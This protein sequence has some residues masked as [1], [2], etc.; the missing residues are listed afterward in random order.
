MGV[1]DLD[2][3][4]LTGRLTLSDQLIPRLLIFALQL[5][6]VTF[7]LV[8]ALSTPSPGYRV[9]WILLMSVVLVPG[10]YYSFTWVTI[11]LDPRSRTLTKERRPLFLRLSSTRVPFSQI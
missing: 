7:L 4:H 5:P 9:F 10:L 3:D 2:E 11:T 8:L 1:R 6:L